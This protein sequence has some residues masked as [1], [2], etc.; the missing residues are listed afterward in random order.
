MTPSKMFFTKG[1][2]VH[3]DRLASFEAALRDAGIEKCNLVYVSSIFPPNCKVLTKEKGV[4]YLKAGQITFC[5]MAR[6][7]T[8]EPNRLISAA[9]GLALPTNTNAY[10]YLSEHHS[11]GE[12]GKKA[13]EYAEDLAATMLA[14]TLGLEFDADKA[15]DERKQEY[16]SSGQI[17]KTT[18]ICQST[19]GNKDGLWT[20]VLA[21]AVLII[22]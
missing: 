4:E 19:E 14:T 13:G 18:N 21:A 12:T 2:G 1:V 8:N 3:K 16:I 22:E 9:I 17:F 20:T 11:F 5:V 15:W 6:M 7:E 10:G